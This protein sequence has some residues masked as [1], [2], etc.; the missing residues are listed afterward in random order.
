MQNRTTNSITF[1]FISARRWLYR[2]DYGTALADW[3]L[4]VYRPLNVQ[5]NFYA[6][7]LFSYN[8]LNE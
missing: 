5:P 8:K 6:K 2:I 1:I 4:R 3:P 7:G